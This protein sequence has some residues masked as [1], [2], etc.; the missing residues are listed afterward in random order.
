[1]AKKLDYDNAFAELR[2]I[3]SKLQDADI[4]IESL[5]Q[6]LNRANE[7]RQFCANRLR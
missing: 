4:N 2:D 1:M 6:Y 3:V 5:S 7:L